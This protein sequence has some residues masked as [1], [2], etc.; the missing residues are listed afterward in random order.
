MEP[1]KKM[2]IFQIVQ[3]DLASIGY[4]ANESPLNNDILSYGFKNISFTICGLVY[5][6]RIAET[7]EE[8][9]DSIFVI[10]V[11]ILVFISFVS[12][13]QKMATIFIF[14]DET[15]KFINGS[16]FDAHLTISI[17]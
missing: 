16:E 7:P 17:E 10:T 2:K 14:I 12:T 15:E 5:L 9:M 3:N 11:G 8:F 13:V 1:M 6:C 4:R